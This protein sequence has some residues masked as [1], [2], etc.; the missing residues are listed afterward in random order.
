MKHEQ[1]FIN[2][3]YLYVLQKNELDCAD[4]IHIESSLVVFMRDHLHLVNYD[5][6][7]YDKFIRFQFHDNIIIHT[8]ALYLDKL[9]YA[10]ES[11][12][13]NDDFGVQM[14]GWCSN[15]PIDISS[16]EYQTQLNKYAIV[17]NGKPVLRSI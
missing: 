11:I 7:E 17:E 4:D 10:S 16:Y 15:E 8:N 12:I 5:M 3:K 2:P 14:T 9:G 6:V 13:V 1:K